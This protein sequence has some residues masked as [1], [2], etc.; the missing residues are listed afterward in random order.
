MA[1]VSRARTL[2]TA[3][4]LPPESITR[5]APTIPGLK[6]VGIGSTTPG[7]GNLVIGYQTEADK[8]TCKDTG[9]NRRVVGLMSTEVGQPSESD[10]PIHED[11]GTIRARAEFGSEA[12]GYEI[13]P[14]NTTGKVG[15]PTTTVAKPGNVVLG[16][17]ALLSDVLGESTTVRPAHTGQAALGQHAEAHAQFIDVA[18]G[19]VCL[20]EE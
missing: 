12:A 20:K 14:D 18:R 10:T 13:V 3:L 2:L 19:S 5:L 8:F 7:S 16:Q 11:T 1:L 15:G 17:L 9:T 6:D 4:P